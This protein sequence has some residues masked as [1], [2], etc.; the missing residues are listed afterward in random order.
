[1]FKPQTFRD[2]GYSHDKYWY[3]PIT[4]GTTKSWTRLVS[5]EMRNSTRFHEFKPKETKHDQNLWF[6]ESRNWTKEL[7]AW[8]VPRYLGPIDIIPFCCVNRKRG[9]LNMIKYGW[10]MWNG[11]LRPV[12]AHIDGNL[13]FPACH[14][15]MAPV[16]RSYSP[17]GWDLQKER[18]FDRAMLVFWTEQASGGWFNLFGCKSTKKQRGISTKKYERSHQLVIE[19]LQTRENNHRR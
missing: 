19:H 1:M 5:F 16:S 2:L 14:R 15:H 7:G 12:G 9:W 6:F 11:H 4:V 3:V 18:F 10:I 17:N 13:M 8:A